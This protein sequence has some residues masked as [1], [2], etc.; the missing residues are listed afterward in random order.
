MRRFYVE[1]IENDVIILP[2]EESKHVVRVLRMNN[3][4]SIE[5]VDGKGTLVTAQ[6]T[7]DHPKK[8]S[9]QVTERL[10]MSND[11][12]SI[13]IAIA[14]TKNLDRMEWLV[15]KCTEL[16]AHK[17]SFLNCEN[18]ERKV[19]KTER[20]HKIAI[21]AMKQS[22]RY[23]LPEISELIDF[24]AFISA[25]PKGYL[26]HC[27]ESE[28]SSLFSTYSEEQ[29]PILIGPEGDFSEKEVEKAMKSGYI[30]ITLGNTRL[31]TETAGLYACS[32]AKLKME[33]R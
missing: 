17:I 32:I 28:K 9:V 19:L 14:P 16:G 15:E 7:S 27:N 30:S 2:E 26:A 24:D 23:F 18:N 6:I 21:S 31:R 5:L 3:G 22:K 1:H 25:Y 8:C 12:Y 33:E 13:H 11:P 10:K 20:L 4:D 29:F